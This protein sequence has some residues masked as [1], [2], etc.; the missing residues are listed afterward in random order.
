MGSTQS[1]L[2]DGRIIAAIS[3][4]RFWL[5]RCDCL[6]VFP[7]VLPP[8][9]YRPEG[10]PP[11]AG[12]FLEQFRLKLKRSFLDFSALSLGRLVRYR[13]PGDVREL[14]NVIERTVILARSSTIEIDAQL[15]AHSECAGGG[16]GDG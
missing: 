9:R 13:R 10:F 1:I 2:V 3:T 16:R 4:D 12:H 14:Q 7:V 11:L 8:F 6:H 15:L 5:D